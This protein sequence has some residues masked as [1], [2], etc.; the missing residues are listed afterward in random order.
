MKSDPPNSQWPKRRVVLLGASNLTRGLPAALQV[1]QQKWGAPLDFMAALGHGRSYGSKHR[2]LGRS[3]RGIVDC[4]IWSALQERPSADTAALI[5]D[6][7]NDIVYGARVDEIV[8]WVEQ[9]LQQL[10]RF[11]KQIVVTELPIASICSVS[12]KKFLVA[13]QI[14]FPT[15]RLKFEDAIERATLLNQRIELLAKAHDV[16]VVEQDRQWYGVDPIHIRR[17][18]LFAAWNRLLS[19]WHDGDACSIERLPLFFKARLRLARP[20][21]RWLFG[22]HQRKKQPVIQ[23]SNGTRISLY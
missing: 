17:R 15:S 3:L 16:A 4:G 14:L 5:T 23:C 8:Q 13:R 22:L 19:P 12:R 1:A 18:F 2:V 9:C 11:T 7:G 20:E 10:L 21:E 6:V